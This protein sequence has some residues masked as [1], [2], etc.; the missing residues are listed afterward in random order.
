MRASEA[1]GSSQEGINLKFF[2]D[3]HFQKERRLDRKRSIIE[4]I[5]L[6]TMKGTRM[7]AKRIMKRDWVP[8]PVSQLLRLE[9]RSTSH[10]DHPQCHVSM[11]Q[12]RPPVKTSNDYGNRQQSKSRVR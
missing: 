10:L 1:A 9:L 7:H 4:D 2:M 11:S 3:M 12:Y 6:D 8:M 5:M